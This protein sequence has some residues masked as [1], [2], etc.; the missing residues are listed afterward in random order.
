MEQIR[1]MRWHASL[2]FPFCAYS[3]AFFTR[4]F[5]TQW[6]WERTWKKWGSNDAFK[7][8]L[9]F[10]NSN[11]SF[12]TIQ[13]QYQT[14]SQKGYLICHLFLSKV[15]LGLGSAS[16]FFNMYKRCLYLFH[17][18]TDDEQQNKNVSVFVSYPFRPFAGDILFVSSTQCEFDGC[19]SCLL[20]RQTEAHFFSLVSNQSQVI[21]WCWYWCYAAKEEVASSYSAAGELIHFG[22]FK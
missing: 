7:T 16:S 12:F 5:Q 19:V 8:D 3:L 6:Q 22:P 18:I 4:R 10:F 9:L 20:R 21:C 11:L 2:P 14:E 15:L 17:K 1:P 13:W